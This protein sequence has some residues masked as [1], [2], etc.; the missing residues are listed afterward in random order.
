MRSQYS[1]Q[2]I[3]LKTLRLVPSIDLA[4]WI[5]I[6]PIILFILCDVLSL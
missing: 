1:A 5:A 4:A 2:V 3:D 6:P